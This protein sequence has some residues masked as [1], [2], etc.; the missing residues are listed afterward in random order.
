M[1]G[2]DDIIER[3]DHVAM[4]VRDIS[5]TLPLVRLMGG[6]FLQGADHPR[7][8]F[9]WVHFAL[10]GPSKL[11]LM[12]PLGD[13]S[14]L[15]KFI[16]RRGEGFHH[17]TFKVNDVEAAA[18]RATEQGFETTGLNIHPDWSEVFLH[19]RTAHGALIQ[20]AAWPESASWKGPTLEEVLGGL[21]L[22]LT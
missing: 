16:D 9:R 14:F 7:N 13:A 2:F 18:H 1:E 5:A 20:M 4:A 10:P 22:D 15:T 19:P 8:Q 3:F 21:S 17:I 11:E 6:E 12:Q